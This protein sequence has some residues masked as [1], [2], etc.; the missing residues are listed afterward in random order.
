[1]QINIIK[2]IFSYELG[3]IILFNFIWKNSNACIIKS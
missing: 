1:M 2:K 3:F